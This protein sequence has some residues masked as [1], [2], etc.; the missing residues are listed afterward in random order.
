MDGSSHQLLLALVGG[1][2][3]PTTDRCLMGVGKQ[4]EVRMLTDRGS[5]DL[6]A[7]SKLK[8]NIVLDADPWLKEAG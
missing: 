3:L 4:P 2:V 8:A 1:F 7:K 6:A 5:D